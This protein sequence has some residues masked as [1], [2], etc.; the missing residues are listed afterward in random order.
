MAFG[1]ALAVTGIQQAAAVSGIINQ[2]VYNPPTVIKG[3]TDA[4]GREAP[5]ERRP[6]RRVI[7]PESSAMVRDLMGAVI[8]TENGQRHLKL[9]DYTRVARPAPRS[10]RIPPVAAIGAMSPPSSA[11]RHSTILGY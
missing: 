9:D 1:Q 10:G 4:D 2:G 3:A 8:D 7:S 11:S 5:F 6:P